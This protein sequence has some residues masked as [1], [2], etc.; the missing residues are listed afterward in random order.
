[1]LVP[2]NERAI[3]L[4]K[5]TEL[6]RTLDQRDLLYLASKMSHRFFAR[7]ERLLTQGEALNEMFLISSGLVN[8]YRNDDYGAPV[9]VA[10]FGKGSLV[11]ELSA[12]MKKLPTAS[13]IAMLDTEA[14]ALKHDEFRVVLNR[15]LQLAL[16]INQSLSVDMCAAF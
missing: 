15:S 2:T 13:V 11:G 1:M 10:Q 5:E 6:F 8:V 4:L 7:G 9:E 3:K 16:S 14:W 12:L